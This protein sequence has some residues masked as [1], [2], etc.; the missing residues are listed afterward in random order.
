MPLAIPIVESMMYALSFGIVQPMS[1]PL[2]ISPCARSD[3][4]VV[5]TMS[6]CVKSCDTC[7]CWLQK[8]R[9]EGFSF[10]IAAKPGSMFATLPPFMRA[11]IIRNIVPWVVLMSGIEILPLYSGFHMSAYDCGAVFTLLLVVGDHLGHVHELGVRVA[12]DPK[13]RIE[14]RHVRDGGEIERLHRAPRCSPAPRRPRPS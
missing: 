12:A 10:L 13:L 4:H 7:A 1:P 9:M 8:V 2:S 6:P 14:L 5:I 3:V 11:A